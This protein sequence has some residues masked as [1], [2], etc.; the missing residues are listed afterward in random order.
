MPS[1][2]PLQ[3][4]VPRSPSPASSRDAQREAR[5]RCFPPGLGA[6]PR[7]SLPPLQQREESGR[8]PARR[9]G[10]A[11]SAASKLRTSPA[12]GS[13]AAL[14]GSGEARAAARSVSQPP[15]AFWG[16]MPPVGLC[17]QR[18]RSDLQQRHVTVV[19]EE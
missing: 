16:A 10:E 3:Q 13:L 7:A 11:W 5:F 19:C 15:G 8:E 4:L 17:G 18:Y 2:C 14:E 12:D 9:H 6:A 1:P